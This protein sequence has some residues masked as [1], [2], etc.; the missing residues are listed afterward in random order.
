M[1]NSTPD[2]QAKRN[3]AVLIFAQAILGAQM[4]I[5]FIL[6]GLAGQSLAA[7]VCYATLPISMIIISSI[8][9]A[10]MISSIMQRCGRKVGFFVGAGAGSIGAIIGSFGLYYDSFALFLLGS[11]FSGIYMS[12]QG[13]YRFAASDTASD[14]FRPKAIS[15]VLAGGLLAAI[16]GPQL[17]KM[18]SDAFVIPFLG[19]YMAVIALNVFGAIIFVFLDLPRPVQDAKAS[20]SGRSV[21]ELLRSPKIATALLAAI[22]C[23]SMMTLVM[24]AT[25]LALVGCGYSQN[26]AADVVSAHVLAMFIPSFFTGNLIVR[27]GVE[28]IILCGI[29]LLGGACI[30]GLNGITIGNFYSALV[31]VGLG[32]NFSFIGATTLLT[33]AHSPAERGRTQGMNDFFVAASITIASFASGGLMNCSGNS[34]AEGWSAVIMTMIPLLT[35]AAMAILWQMRQSAVQPTSGL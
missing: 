9:S 26:T 28:R 33:S 12:A 32:W 18:T 17:A 19:A 22:I 31:L 14:A 27:F 29:V 15:Y 24:T 11:L 4:P 10:P 3:V 23:Y 13:F 16:I 8:P 21:F 25:P 20:A 2:G 34:S 30:A 6:A 1:N 5:L 35:L 7:N